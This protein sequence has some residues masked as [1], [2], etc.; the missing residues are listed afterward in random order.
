MVSSI[1][2][3][4]QRQNE[5]LKLLSGNAPQTGQPQCT[6]MVLTVSCCNSGL[7]GFIQGHR[8]SFK[9]HRSSRFHRCRAIAQ[10]PWNLIGQRGNSGC[11]DWLHF[12][13][14]ILV[15]PGSQHRL[16]EK[17]KGCH[18]SK[19]LVLNSSVS[20]FHDSQY[21][22]WYNSKKRICHSKH[23]FYQVWDLSAIF[24]PKYFWHF[25]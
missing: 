4:W 10:C 2:F 15:K 17:Q 16:E 21:Q 25:I 12:L 9:R 14:V 22:F 6:R 8:G 1:E 7:L 23:N 11:A 20:K 19:I 24:V 18:D 5:R 13:Y 3:Y